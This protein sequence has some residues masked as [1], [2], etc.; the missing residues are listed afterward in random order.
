MLLVI[1]FIF[2]LLFS[3]ALCD[4]FLMMLLCS[5]LEVTVVLLSQSVWL[6]VSD[7]SGSDSIGTVDITYS[8]AWLFCRG[9]SVDRTF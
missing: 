9:F 4:L 1:T 2:Y 6:L 8:A 5:F 7:W 3:G